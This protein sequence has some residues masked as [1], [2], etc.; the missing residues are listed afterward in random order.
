MFSITKVNSQSQ[1]HTWHCCCS[2]PSFWGAQSAAWSYSS[3]QLYDRKGCSHPSSVLTEIFAFRA[4]QFG[5]RG[6]ASG[7]LSYSS[8]FHHC[9]VFYCSM[10]RGC[11]DTLDYPCTWLQTE[12]FVIAFS[13][14]TVTLLSCGDH[15]LQLGLLAFEKE[16]IPAITG[17]NTRKSCCGL[18]QPEGTWGFRH[19]PR[20]HT[21]RTGFL[22]LV[23]ELPPLRHSCLYG[24]VPS[25]CCAS[26][27]AFPCLCCCQ[28]D[29][30]RAQSQRVLQ[31]L[32][33]CSVSGEKEISKH[34]F[35]ILLCDLLCIFSAF[36]AIVLLCLLSPF[37]FLLTKAHVR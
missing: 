5:T 31:M 34:P 20:A 27:Q 35:S 11:C 18:R 7:H 30:A 32:Q 9:L 13:G 21:H 17:F 1:S 19:L 24:D 36:K 16:A 28:S 10:P 25:G 4:L 29:W 3:L 2:I 23:A 15:L 37:F 6:F 22:V 14:F 26:S 33:Y 12:I 8:G